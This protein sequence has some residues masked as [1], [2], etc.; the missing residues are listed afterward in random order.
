MRDR[1]HHHFCC[2]TCFRRNIEG[3]T[4]MKIQWKKLTENIWNVPNVLTMLRL[5]LVPFFLYFA[6]HNNR[7]IALIIFLGACL[8][9]LFDGLVARRT[10]K[11]TDF[12]KLMD[13][14]AD[15]LMVISALLF[16]SIVGAVPWIVVAI[17]LL[18]ESLMILGGVL[19]LKRGIVVYANWWGKSAQVLFI[20]GLTL[21]FFREEFQLLQFPAD[22]I[23]LWAAV[24]LSIM[25]MINYAFLAKKKALHHAATADTEM[26]GSTA[27]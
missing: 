13:P 17:V 23:V 19:M 18:K 11:I 10:G 26:E 24:A 8:T 25:A 2:R 15:K 1:N 3:L 20:A 16:R 7:M 14:L 12:G 5:V 6:I 9:D 4:C 27:E 21:S 22:Q